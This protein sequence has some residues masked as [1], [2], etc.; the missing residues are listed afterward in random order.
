MSLSAEKI[1]KE[2]EM[3]IGGRLSDEMD[4]GCE[5]S[6]NLPK[7]F[8]SLNISLA[9]TSYQAGRLMLVRSDSES[10]D[11]N[12][13][14][15]V[16]PMGLTA[17]ENGFT[18]GVYTQVIQFHRED[19]LINK[20]KMPLQRIEDD[21]TAK[22]VAPTPEE[23]ISLNVGKGFS[24][25]ENK[26]IKEEKEAFDEY[27]NKLYEPVDSRVDACF[28]VRSSHYTGMINIHDIEWGDEGLWVVNS[29][30]SCVSTL[31]P[32][33]SF[34]PRWKPPFISDL[35][36]EDRCHLNG[37]TLKDGKPAFVTTFSKFDTPNKWRKNT[38]F[39]GTLIDVSSNE[40]VVDGLAMPHS[41]RWHNGKVYFCNSGLGQL[42][43]YDPKTRVSRVLA[44][45]QGFTRGIDFVG[46][47]LILGLSKV[48]ESTVEK[49]APLA[50]KYAETFSGI[51]LFN[52]ADNTEIGHLKFT[53]NVDQIYDVA[54]IPDCTF[55]EVIEANHPR[56]RNHFC[57][58]SLQPI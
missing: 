11:V 55:P 42:C 26:K 24:D 51:W 37:M 3:T 18:L 34:V 36:P 29:S 49:P 17:T 46:N 45:V 58:P 7:I 2:D 8:Q 43:C 27:Q 28:I 14:S 53:G 38:V 57:F 21:V 13:K 5:Y 12:F 31:D 30:F 35:A 10:L 54:V 40:I 41:P 48:R 39:D 56:V 19:G 25:E 16:R 15:F 44:E 4:F 32:N 6:A 52:L 22:K 47:I 20:L 23:Q 9:F 1:Q 50:E 33:Y